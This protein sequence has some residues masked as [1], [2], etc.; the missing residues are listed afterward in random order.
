MFGDLPMNSPES[1]ARGIA[2]ASADSNLN[3]ITL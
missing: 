1:V 3:G 2:Q